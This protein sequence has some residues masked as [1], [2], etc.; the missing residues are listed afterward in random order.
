M[1]AAQ[2][3]NNITEI[4]IQGGSAKVD[5]LAKHFNVS[6]ETI[7]RDFIVLE[8]EGFVQ[9]K[10]GGAI[11]TFELQKMME[12]ISPVSQ[13]MLLN[14][15]EKLRIGEKAAGMVTPGMGIFLDSG[16]TVWSML[17]F[18]KKTDNLTI[19]TNSLDIAKDCAEKETWTVIILGGQLIEKS[20]CM[21]GPTAE[22]Q[23]DQLSID[24]AFMGTIG[25]SSKGECT[26]SNLFE[27][28]LKKTVT[29]VARKIVLLADS[30]K[31]GK[32][33]HFT[34]ARFSQ[35]HTIIT[36]DKADNELKNAALAANT[37][38]IMVPANNICLEND[39]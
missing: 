36:T 10:H 38:L 32:S 22:A 34:F 39:E 15:D 35:L 8:Q 30:T 14:R 17:Q 2:R 18:I 13:R 33:A 4:I 37:Q 21:V 12:H 9:K 7:R 20:M 26:S 1:I 31:L 5:E 19:I 23:L 11:A 25:V 28:N 3:R 6:Q 16:S 24:L 29:S 27:A